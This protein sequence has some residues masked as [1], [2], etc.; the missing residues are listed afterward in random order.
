MTDGEASEDHVRVIV[1]SKGG[2]SVQEKK[3][4]VHWQAK[5][6]RADLC[7]FA[8]GLLGSLI[9]LLPPM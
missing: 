2:A 6:T 1:T 7:G 3:N 9:D 4:L 8:L 5:R